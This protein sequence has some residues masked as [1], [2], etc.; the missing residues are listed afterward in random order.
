E[1]LRTG[2]GQAGR[3]L[4][5][6]LDVLELEREGLERISHPV[7]VLEGSASEG[8]GPFYRRLAAEQ[9]H[10]GTL[11][12]GA[13]YGRLLRTIDPSLSRI[14][15]V[16]HPLRPAEVWVVAWGEASAAAAAEPAFEPLGAQRLGA[17]RRYLQQRVPLGTVVQVVEPM[18]IPFKVYLGMA[19]G[20]G[21]SSAAGSRLREQ[22]AS[23]LQSYLDPLGGG[24]GGKG[25]PLVTEVSAELV[26][27]V[28]GSLLRE[29][30][31]KDE[32]SL[33]VESSLDSAVA[34]DLPIAVAVLDTVEIE[35]GPVSVEPAVE[36]RS[37]A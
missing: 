7:S 14:E 34:L 21:E 20:A 23:S 18:R 31:G 22:L 2:I 19:G 27:T 3:A 30:G 5:D 32:L 25:C 35:C 36:D 4:R 11:V 1:G 15:V 37:R 17:L 16:P 29:A 10:G 28:A 6:S 33:R 9:A 8:G 13:D 24:A 12:S 26:S